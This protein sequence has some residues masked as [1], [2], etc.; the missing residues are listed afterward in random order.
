MNIT[1]AARSLAFVSALLLSLALAREATAAELRVPANYPTIQAAV[2]AAK[3]DDVIRIAAGVYTDQ[4]R[5]TSKRLTLIGQPGA[6]LRATK[7]MSPYVSPFPGVTYY[8]VQIILAELA[9]V[10]VR[11][12]T[13]EGERLAESFEGDG[14][15]TG[16]YLLRSTGDVQDCSFH[17]FRGKTFGPED[18]VPIW[19]RTFEEDDVTVRVTG[20]TFTDGLGAIFLRGGRTGQTITATIEGNTIIGLGPVATAL[21]SAGIDVRPGVGGRIVGNTISEFSETG[22][23]AEFPISF[24]VLASDNPEFTPVRPLQIEGNTFRNNQMHISLTKAHG[25]L[26]QNNRFEGTAPGIA[27]L[28]VAVSGSNIRI[29]GNQFENM[30]EGIRLLGGEPLRTELPGLPLGDV[31]GF[32]VNAQVTSNRFCNVATPVNHQEPATF[33]ERGTQ[34]GSCASKPLVISPAVLLSWPADGNN[35]ALE[36]APNVG[37]P[38]KESDAAP[39]RKSG[40]YQVTVPTDS[41]NQ[42]FRLR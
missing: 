13:F 23:T 16:L 6:I 14:A 9:D 7:S 1:I 35:A 11:G 42:Y 31:L 4:V 38:W 10:T 26:I 15:L 28:G 2:D 36:V 40:R 41:L 34:L 39:R 5:I 32:A 21:G 37:G 20:C 17:G 29:V 12:L 25:S 27:P 30:P 18:A 33:I 8:G 22:T 19:C 3:A 24:G